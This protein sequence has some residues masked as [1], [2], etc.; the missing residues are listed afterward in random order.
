MEPLRKANTEKIILK[1][2]LNIFMEG[3]NY[4]HANYQIIKLFMVALKTKWIGFSQK[5]PP[6]VS[7][8]KDLK[9][10]AKF[11][12]K[13]FCWSLTLIKLQA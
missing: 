3:P 1:T 7:I 10:F 5:Q 2:L 6:E 8:K 9:N 12:E 11:T 4:F 13:H